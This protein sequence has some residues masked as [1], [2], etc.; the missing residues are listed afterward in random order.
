MFISLKSYQ[1]FHAQNSPL[2]AP[3]HTSNTSLSKSFRRK[4]EKI[5]Y[6]PQITLLCLS[7]FTLQFRHYTDHFSSHL[8]IRGPHFL[9]GKRISTLSVIYTPIRRDEGKISKQTIS[10]FSYLALVR[11]R[12]REPLC[13]SASK[14]KEEETVTRST[15]KERRAGLVHE[16]HRRLKSLLFFFFIW[17]IPWL[18][19]INPSF[20]RQPFTRVHVDF[21]KISNLFQKSQN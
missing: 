6:L 17:Y 10:I 8:L 2:P 18:N 9:I 12:R 16:G 20:F 15:E 11:F 1:I 4:P 21:V 13:Q 3:S 14:R 19:F 7:S 5:R